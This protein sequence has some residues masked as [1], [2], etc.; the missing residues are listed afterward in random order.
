MR[1]RLTSLLLRTASATV[2]GLL[3]GT[4]GAQS[5]PYYLGIS[6]A[7]NVDSNM[8]RAAN[9]ATLSDGFSRSDTVYS[10]ALQAGLD[11][12]IGRQRVYG[13][14]ALRSTRYQ[15][16]DTF[17][18]EGYN[19]NV[20]LNW[21]TVER[22]SG[23]LSASANRSLASFSDPF[24]SGLRSKNLEDSTGLEFSA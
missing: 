16:N 1:L 4:A 24:I 14:L 19:A 7:V 5:S 18:N 21:E 12:P 6:Q 2:A 3:C 9:G 8:L 22:L 13:S 17:N 10:T 23:T 20:G 11:Q 15:H